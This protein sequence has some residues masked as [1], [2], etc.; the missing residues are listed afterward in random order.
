MGGEPG[1]KLLAARER[2]LA[3]PLGS[4]QEGLSLLRASDLPAKTP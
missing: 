1:W 2:S 3:Q 4:R